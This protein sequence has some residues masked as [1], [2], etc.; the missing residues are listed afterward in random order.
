MS[1]YREKEVQMIEEP[2]KIDINDFLMD[3]IRGVKKLWWL[4]IG[5]A[6]VF[7]AVS[8]LKVS[9]TYAPTYV[10]SATMAVNFAGTNASYINIESAQQMAEVFPYILTSGVL[11]DVVA[12]DLGMEHVPGT[13]SAAAEDGI[14]LFTITVTS[15]NA[16][17]AYDVLQSVIKNYPNVARF[18]LGETTLTIMDETGVLEDTGKVSVVRGSLK[19]GVIKGGA[20][21]LLIMAIYVLTRRTV[22]S[23]K[24]LKRNINLEDYGSIP[25]IPEKK[26]RKREYTMH[27]NLL[28]ERVPQVYLEAVR[29]L[30]IKTMKEMEQKK[31]KSLMI[32]S[33]VPGEGKTTLA[34]NLAIAVA[35]QGKRV[36]LVDADPRNP[37]VAMQ[38][39]ASNEKN[40]S[41]GSVLRG[42]NSVEEALTDI[43]VFDGVLRVLLGA[44]PEAKDAKLLG[45]AAMKRLI[46]ELEAQ[47]D[48]VI[49]DTAPSELLADAPALAKYVDAALYVVKYDYAKIRQIRTG[50]QALAMSGVHIIGYTFNGDQAG[51]QRGY[52]YGYNGG[53]GGYGGYGRYL[54]FKARRKDRDGRIIKD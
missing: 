42:E 16:Q 25:Y 22:K 46:Q 11:Q 26:R 24:E 29:K 9:T 8:Y 31:F 34:V 23:R 48:I 4:V 3:M 44:D 36:I 45:T 41:L 19:N 40:A 28:N 13:I 52:G 50:I 14:N 15:E 1:E 51:H 10:A 39:N 35:K 47:A 43:R 6:A 2:D 5:L 54:G 53:Y 21:G 30:S 18:V 27:V 33:S 38:M 20:L 12:E 32:T 49:L 17:Q 7:G 37:S